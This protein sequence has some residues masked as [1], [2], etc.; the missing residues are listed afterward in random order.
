MGFLIL[1]VVVH[2]ASMLHHFVAMYSLLALLRVMAKLS[3]VQNCLLKAWLDGKKYF[4][5]EK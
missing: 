5:C 3:C 2:K 1:F 4:R